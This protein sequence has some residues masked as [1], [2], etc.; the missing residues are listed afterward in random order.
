MNVKRL[1]QLFDLWVQHYDQL[2]AEAR[3]LLPLR[4]IQF[5]APQG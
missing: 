5:L 3:Q 4:Q 2:P 1:E